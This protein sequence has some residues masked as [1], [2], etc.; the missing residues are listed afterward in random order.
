[1]SGILGLAVDR[2]FIDK[3]PAK[4]KGVRPG[5]RGMTKA[6]EAVALTPDEVRVLLDYTSTDR[7]AA[8][9]GA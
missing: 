6:C 5:E 1:M 2:D 4:R 3:N 8:R 9:R 7:L